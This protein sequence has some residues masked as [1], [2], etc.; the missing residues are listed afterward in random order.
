MEQCFLTP[1]AGNTKKKMASRGSL[2]VRSDWPST[3]TGDTL[4][5]CLTCVLS[6]A[7][8]VPLLASLLIVPLVAQSTPPQYVTKI[9]HTEEG[10]PQ[11]SVNAMLQDHR[12]YIWIGTFGGLARF[13]GARFTLFNSAN[14]SGFG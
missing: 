10:L 11:N 14:T 3:T 13:D 9:W 6:L 8:V 1:S 5:S 2:L 4:D 7:R 12:G